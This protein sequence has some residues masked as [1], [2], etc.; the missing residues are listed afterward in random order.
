MFYDKIDALEK[1]LSLDYISQVITVR[2]KE[3]IFGPPTTPKEE[4][5]QARLRKKLIKLLLEDAALAI[6]EESMIDYYDAE[7]SLC[8]DSDDIAWQNIN[9]I[10]KNIPSRESVASPIDPSSIE[11]IKAEHKKQVGLNYDAYQVK[12]QDPQLEFEHEDD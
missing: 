2:K 10:L 3:F 11:E 6:V 7:M 4:R 1:A 9:A 5:Q 12:M 8:R